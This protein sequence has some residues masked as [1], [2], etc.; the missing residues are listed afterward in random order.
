VRRWR[1][2]AGCAL[3]LG[4]LTIDDPIVLLGDERQVDWRGLR[5]LIH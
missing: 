4:P 3:T 1:P 5:Y 2:P